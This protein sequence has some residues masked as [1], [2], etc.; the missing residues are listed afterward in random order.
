MQVLCHGDNHCGDDGSGE[1][2]QRHPSA[3][4]TTDE[5]PAYDECQRRGDE[6]SVRIPPCRK[7]QKSCCYQRGKAIRRHLS[8][9][10]SATRR[11]LMLPR[12]W[13]TNSYSRSSIHCRIS[14]RINPIRPTQYASS[15]EAI[16]AT[17]APAITAFGTSWDVWTLS[18]V[19]RT[20][21]C[22]HYKSHRRVVRIV[23]CVSSIPNT[24]YAV[25]TARRGQSWP[26]D[27]APS[28]LRLPTFIDEDGGG[29]T[30]CPN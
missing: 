16:M 5:H 4:P 11:W 30:A 2:C 28:G 22:L 24:R 6:Q 25:R 21:R 26:P 18:T 1:C 14:S 29:A 8:L 17:F 23:C 7:E 13:A 12:I 15:S 20:Y 10:G 19:R 3:V 9:A 27:A